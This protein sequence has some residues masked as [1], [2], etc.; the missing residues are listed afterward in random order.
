MERFETN[1]RQNFHAA[2]ESPPGFGVRWLAGNGADTA[3]A[4]RTSGRSIMIRSLII[5]LVLFITAIRIPACT[6][7]VLTDTNRVLFCN[8]EDGPDN[9]TRIWF[10]PA[11]TNHY[12]CVFVG[13]EN[14]WAQGGMNSAGLAFDWLAGWA[15][16]WH[17]DPALPEAHGNQEVIET[18]ATVEEA[19]EFYRAHRDPNLWY[20]KCLLTDKT[21]KSVLIG[22]YRGKLQVWRKS[23][24]WG[25]GYGEYKLRCMLETNS[26]PTLTNATNILRACLQPGKSATRYFN[27][28]DPKSGDIFLYPFP[29]KDIEVK[30]N[31]AAELSKGP[32]YYGMVKIQKQLKQAPRPLLDNMKR[33]SD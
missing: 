16:E 28:F 11:G 24:S 27:V 9:T 30:L 1:E 3:L 26:E 33:F 29:K 32:H 2:L 23:A 15:E 10:Q 13:Y 31:L 7:F 6:V 18:C 14:G 4:N 22:A 19:I 20:S 12:G 5:G 8:N 17:P 25:L 21:G